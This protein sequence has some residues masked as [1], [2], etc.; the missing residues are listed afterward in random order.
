[1]LRDRFTSTYDALGLHG[2]VLGRS[3]SWIAR[4]IYGVGRR[5]RRAGRAL[6]GDFGDRQRASAPVEIDRPEGVEG[7]VAFRIG[8]G[9]GDHLIAARYIRDLSTAAGEFRFDVYSSRPAVARWVFGAI[10]QFNRCYDEYFAWNNSQNYKYYDAAITVTQ[11]VIIHHEHVKWNRL[12]REK[13]K[14]VSICQSIDRFRHAYHLNEII[15]VHPF[16]DGFLGSKAVFMNLSRHTFP[17]AMSGIAY[18]GHR[19]R[20]PLDESMIQSYGLQERRYLTVHNGFDAEFHSA[21]DSTKRSTKAYPHFDLVVEL[22]RARRP[23]LFVVQLGSQTSR[24]IPGVDLQLI[25]KTDLPAVAAILAGSLLHIDSETGL[26]HLAACV[27]TVSCVMFGPT[28]AAYFGYNENINMTPRT[29]GGCWWTTR[30][31]MLNCPRGFKEPICL[32]ETPPEA[33][34]DAIVAY[35]DAREDDADL[36]AGPPAMLRQVS[37]PPST[38][39]LAG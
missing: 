25:N 34:A 12:N 18:G 24:P 20:V 13:P 39:A 27:G 21:P 15:S 29:C 9:I 5:L 32:S 10:S 22:L 2:T 7:L 17:S 31:W 4:L 11:F 30:E 6:R 38:A 36:L 14:L 37:T 8:G 23:D 28:P 16:L 26:V 1:M 3:I 19:L 35:L 33:V